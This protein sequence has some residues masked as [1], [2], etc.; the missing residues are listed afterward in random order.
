[1]DVTI[2]FLKSGWTM[3]RITKYKAD[4]TG[5]ML[6]SSTAFVLITWLTIAA[7]ILH[8]QFYIGAL[9]VAYMWGGANYERAPKLFKNARSA[10]LTYLMMGI[11]LIV[12]V[13][14]ITIVFLNPERFGEY[15]VPAP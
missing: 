14:I 12:I 4:K 7:Q 6:L 9:L 5:H 3:A 15:L 2:D 8:W 13:T 11:G 10:Q 1:M